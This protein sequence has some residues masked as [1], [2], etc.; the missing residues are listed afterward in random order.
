MS[1]TELSPPPRGH[2]TALFIGGFLLAAPWSIC[3]AAGVVYVA[4]KLLQGAG[5]S[6]DAGGATPFLSLLLHLLLLAVL[7]LVV[8]G[9]PVLIGALMMRAG[10]RR[11]GRRLPVF[12]WVPL[13]AAVVVLATLEFAGLWAM[14]YDRYDAKSISYTLWKAGLYDKDKDEIVE[15][16]HNDPERLSVV[17]G[18]SEAQLREM[19]GVLL[20][21]DQATPALN[22]CYQGSSWSHMKARYL[23]NSWFMVVFDHDRVTDLIL[24]KPC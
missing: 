22:A 14:A 3:L 2:G 20:R 5:L 23:R 10:M 18:K 4:R 17:Q 16:L 11:G 19:F 15:A 21:P 1:T 13:A 6:F 24:M 8:L 12:A 7:A 9:W